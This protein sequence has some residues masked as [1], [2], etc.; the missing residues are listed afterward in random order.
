M[1]DKLQFEMVVPERLLMSGEVDQVLVPGSEGDFTVLAYHAPVMSGLRAG[2]LEVTGSEQGDKRFY[3]AAG[4][5][6]VNA[7]G[8]TILAEKAIDM[9]ELSRDELAQDIKDLQE[10]VAD[11]KDDQVRQRAQE[12]LDQTRALLDSL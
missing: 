4:F 6:E 9:A 10:D 1:A 11:A 8:L 12:K 7:K 5:A 2:V 3:V